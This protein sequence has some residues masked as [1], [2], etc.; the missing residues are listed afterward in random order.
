MIQEEE[1]RMRRVA[2][3]FAKEVKK[4]WMK[5]DKLVKLTCHTYLLTHN[6]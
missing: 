5:V 2:S 3:G 4:F 1:Q 6:N